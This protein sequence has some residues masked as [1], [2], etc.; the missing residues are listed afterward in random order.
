VQANVAGGTFKDLGDVHWKG[1]CATKAAS[2]S[3]GSLQTSVALAM[4]A[5]VPG[6]TVKDPGAAHCPDGFL[7]R[8][9][10]NPRASL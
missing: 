10:P 1:G 3:G 6:G 2:N 7:E 4:Q 9:A 5:R 8:P